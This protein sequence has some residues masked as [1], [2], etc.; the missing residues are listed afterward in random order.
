MDRRINSIRGEDAT[1]AE[2]EE[3]SWPALPTGKPCRARCLLSALLDNI[4]EECKQNKE[5]KVKEES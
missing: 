2:D 3:I 5:G 1:Q 4:K